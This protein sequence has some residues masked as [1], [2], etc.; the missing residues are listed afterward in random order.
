MAILYSSSPILSPDSSLSG[1]QR[2]RLFEWELLRKKFSEDDSVVIEVTGTDSAGIPDAYLVEYRLRS[3]CGIR[4]DGSPVFADRFTMELVLPERYP[5]VDAPPRFRFIGETRPWHPNIRYSGDMAGFVCLNPE[6]TF[7]DLA[8]GVE[9]V[10]EYLRYELYHAA[11]EPPYPEDLTVA[12]WVIRQGEPNEWI[13]FD[14]K[15]I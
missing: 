14:Q 7:T 10:S 3:I 6:N 5:Q 12:R 13:F 4:E 1:R 2:R 15:Q 8:W 11:Q 9:R